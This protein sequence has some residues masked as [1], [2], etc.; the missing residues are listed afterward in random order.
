MI[1][2]PK[3]PPLSGKNTTEQLET[4]R[5]YLTIVVEQINWALSHIEA[6]L[7]SVKGNTDKPSVVQ[8]TPP[9]YIAQVAQVDGWDIALY[10]DNTCEME[11]TVSVTPESGSSNNI[12]GVLT[13]ISEPFEEALPVKLSHG[14]V[15]GEDLTE[16]RPV[17]GFTNDEGNNIIYVLKSQ[18]M[19]SGTKLHEV[20]LK[21]S[22]NI[23]SLAEIPSALGG[24][25]NE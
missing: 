12:N 19:Y 6:S 18:R 5:T 10:L 20:R 25:T 2:I 11:T 14:V 21:V 15:T 9:K 4:I 7:E 23:A 24:E 17:F 8:S 16:N 3:P 1:Q 13:Y 22:G